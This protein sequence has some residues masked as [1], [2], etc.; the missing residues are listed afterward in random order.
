[1]IA[2]GEELLKEEEDKSNINSK[3]RSA[4]Q[5]IYNALGDADAELYSLSAALKEDDKRLFEI[6][7]ASNLVSK[8]QE[9]LNPM[10]E[11]EDISLL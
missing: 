8:L 9:L 4:L 3:A 5:N 1:M 10:A 2:F 6:N 11:D 7:K